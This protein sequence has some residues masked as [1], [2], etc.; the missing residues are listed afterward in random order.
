VLVALRLVEE[1]NDR[2]ALVSTHTAEK[3]LGLY[4][5]V[6]VRTKLEKTRH[7]QICKCTY[8]VPCVMWTGSCY[9]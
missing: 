9:V 8:G 4:L 7:H 5:P 3:A 1:R 6:H 2:S